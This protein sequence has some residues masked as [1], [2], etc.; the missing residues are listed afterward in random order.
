MIKNLDLKSLMTQALVLGGQAEKENEVPVGAIITYQGNII[1]QGINQVISN[2]DPTAHAEIIALRQAALHLNT[3]NLSNCDLYVTLEPCAMCAAA[4][5]LARI[6][7]VCFGAY[8][9]KGGGVDHGAKVFNYSLHKPQVYGGIMQEECGD[10]LKRF[11][12]SKR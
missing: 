8:D 9:F 6:R 3:P 11:F 1:A 12:S 10:L 5:S 4:I 7:V 2:C